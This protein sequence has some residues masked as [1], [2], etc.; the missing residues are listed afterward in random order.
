[1]NLKHPIGFAKSKIPKSK[2]KNIKTFLSSPTWTPFEA[3]NCELG[4]LGIVVFT[5][6]TGFLPWNSDERGGMSI[7]GRRSVQEKPFVRGIR[8][9]HPWEK[10]LCLLRQNERDV[11][12]TTETHSLM[13][14]DV[15]SLSPWF[16]HSPVDL[17]LVPRSYLIPALT[18]VHWR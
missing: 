8:A 9:E 14:T 13:F 12:E 18:D 2:K 5:R 1:M 11:W 17:T 10:K 15:N 3:R 4:L 16:Q 7:S 6:K